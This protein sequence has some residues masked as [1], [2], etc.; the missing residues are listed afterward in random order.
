MTIVLRELARDCLK[1]ANGQRD[2]AAEKLL[3]KLKRNHPEIV[4]EMIM[5]GVRDA[6][7]AAA[8]A[9]RMVPSTGTTRNPVEPG[10]APQQSVDAARAFNAYNFLDDY[11]LR[12][13]YLGDATHADIDEMIEYHDHNAKSN[14]MKANFFRS[15]AQ[16]LPG[17]KTVRECMTSDDI[18]ALYKAAGLE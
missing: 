18:A 6:V 15:I 1:T 7:D 11:P 8:R 12:D 9:S 17:G 4:E 5:R 13:C 10:K 3:R 14:E 2:K 16:K